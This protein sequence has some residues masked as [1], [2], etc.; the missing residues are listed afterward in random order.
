MTRTFTTT[1]AERKAVALLL[2]LYGP[3]A[4]GK[5]CSAHRLAVGLQRVSGGR[6]A[7]VDTENG[8]GLHYAPKPGDAAD[9]SRLTFDFDH[10]PLTAPFDSLS[11]LA[12]IEHAVNGGAKVIIVDSGSHEHEGEGGLLER[13][14]AE[15]DRIAG[16]DWKKRERVKFAAW[17][18]PKQDR[19]RLINRVLQLNVHVI[20]CFRAKEKMGLE[21]GKD[22]V[23][24]GWMPVGAPEMAYEFA[25]GAL[26]P[27]GA[28]G[29]PDWTPERPG[30]R[31]MVKLPNWAKGLVPNKGQPLDED[32]GERLALWAAGDVPSGDAT[33]SPASSRAP[34]EAPGLVDKMLEA[35]AGVTDHAT[36]AKY[37]AKRVAVWD[38]IHPEDQGKLEAAVANARHR[39]ESRS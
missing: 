4:G 37:E 26:L 14:E 2:G 19:Q 1:K 24:L 27:P 31:T 21:R 30:E 38:D 17:I 12:A 28:N 3:S 23:S 35:Y 33:P 34:A 36:L 18:K 9:P 39:V 7:M 11:Y 22:P 15:L 20:W 32:T 6:V 25:V 5:T 29:V 10:I 13:H 8:R 16:N